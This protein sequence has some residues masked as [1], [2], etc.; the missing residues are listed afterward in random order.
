MLEAG[1]KENVVKTS[2]LPRNPELEFENV[3]LVPLLKY[4]ESRDSGS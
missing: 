1:H 4:T 3:K 2:D